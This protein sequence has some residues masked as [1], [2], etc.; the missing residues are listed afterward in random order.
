MGATLIVKVQEQLDL[1][2]RYLRGGAGGDLR[3][4]CRSGA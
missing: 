1:D 4:P 2:P 3:E